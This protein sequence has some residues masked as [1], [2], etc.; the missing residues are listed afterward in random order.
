MKTSTLAA[1]LTAAMLC[2][3]ATFAI[4]QPQGSRDSGWGW[5][6]GRGM[7]GSWHDGSGSMMHGRGMMGSW[8]GDDGGAMM[9]G[10]GMM[11]GGPAQY[12]DGRIAFLRTE[13][14]ITEEQKPLFDSYAN[15]LRQSANSMQAMHERM[16]SRDVPATAPGRLQWHIDEMAQRLA[17]LQALK[18]VVEP[19]YEALSEQQKAVADE[20]LSP[21]GM[22]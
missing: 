6:H 4:A 21:M 22:M 8:H 13:L 16:W 5:D 14:A 17:A 9:G 2:A 3:G 20:L 11:G 18:D 1:V 10:R 15:A 7:M 12:I 19:L